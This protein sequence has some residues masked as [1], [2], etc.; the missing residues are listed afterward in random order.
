MVLKFKTAI[1]VTLASS[2]L[3]IPLSFANSIYVESNG[4]VGIGTASPQA[5]LHVNTTTSGGQ[6]AIIES[7]ALGTDVLRI[8]GDSDGSNGGPFYTV[9][10]GNGN[11]G[12]GTANPQAELH[13]NT[14]TSGGQNA[15]IESIALGTDVLRIIGDSDGNNGG[16]FYTVFRG[17]GNVGV[18]TA[19]P[20]A[21][22]HIVNDASYA[23]KIERPFADA[24]INVF[25]AGTASYI[26]TSDNTSL[27]FG[28]ESSHGRLTIAEN[29]NVGIATL[30]PSYTL[31][32]NGT[33]RGNNVSPSDI[34]FKTNIS[35]IE[36]PL[37][38]ISK[39]RGVT[40]EWS[41]P[42]RG[43]GEQI[44]L[45]AQEVEQVFPEAVSTDTEGYKSVAYATLVGPLIE[46]VKT[47]DKENGILKQEKLD[48]KDQVQTL[49]RQMSNVLDRLE[50]LENHSL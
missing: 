24:K 20:S 26:D 44:G 9:F 47:L 5:E 16:P 41:D 29:G 11:V 43:V 34:R 15:I 3:M 21:A 12:I 37:D 27:R 8:I 18:G 14:T 7:I 33:I 39:L 49:N 31:D 28:H 32:V 6:N 42:S 36:N 48:L 10:R 17:N 46:A 23:M 2:L 1:L 19:S 13:V 4:N 25:L 45:I 35:T 22:L 50:Q 38:K 40:Y 30:T